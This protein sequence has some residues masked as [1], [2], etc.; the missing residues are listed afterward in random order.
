VGKSV[1]YP[2]Y[3][4]LVI[5]YPRFLHWLFNLGFIR[6]IFGVPVISSRPS[7]QS[8]VKPGKEHKSQRDNGI[9][10]TDKNDNREDN[11]QKIAKRNYFFCEQ[12]FFLS[13][14]IS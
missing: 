13:N 7:V 14:P 10:G 3:Q 2:P 12:G 5:A 6:L 8:H 1:A 11:D 9:A 4:L